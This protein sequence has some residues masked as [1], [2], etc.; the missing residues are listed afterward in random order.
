[1]RRNLP[2]TTMNVSLEDGR[3]IV[4]KTDLKGKITYVNPYFVEVSGFTEEELLG[5]PH[6]LVRH[7]DMPPE[8][9]A[10]LWETLKSGIPWTGMVKNRCKNGDYYWVYANVTPVREGDNV[11]GYMSVRTKPS[12]AQIDAAEELYRRI[13]EGKAM[14]LKI[15]RG[16]PV[17]TGIAGWIASLR[18]M[19]T[20]R[21]LAL[22]MGSVCALFLSLGIA[23]LCDMPA[24]WIAALCATGVAAGAMTWRSLHAGVVQPVRSALRAARTIAGGDLRTSFDTSRQDDIGQLMTALQQMNVNLQAI[25]G[26]VRS[27]VD[28]MSAGS[29]EIAAGNLGLSTRTE[30]QAASLEETASTMEELASAVQQNA[31]HT[32]QANDLGKA[33]TD[34]AAQGCAAIEQMSATMNGISASS[35]KIV[36]II[37]LIDGIAFQTNILALNA[38]VEAARAGEQG[39]GFAVVAAEVRTLAQRSAGA[40]KEIKS[41]IEASVERVDAGTKQVE[42]AGTTIGRIAE[43]VR[44][45]SCIMG[46]ISAASSEQSDGIEQV[47][48]ALVQMDETTQQNAALVEEAAAASASLAEQANRLSQV[49]AMFRLQGR[50]T[51]A[52][53]NVRLLK[54]PGGALRPGSAATGAAGATHPRSYRELRVAQM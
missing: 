43:S 11:V 38:A 52:G 33:T 10:D 6:N 40:A 39:R 16:I 20:G 48:L 2:V 35:H 8:A 5:S 4:S 12:Q 54:Q 25:I 51:W 36:E 23:A 7:P 50:D 27:N 26:D 34:L 17:R 41:L 30:E 32:S 44:Q 46:D 9:F 28:T 42:S 53:N 14:G 3:P 47:N 29:Q 21:R 18:N 45:V 24:S 49:I 31:M 19:T 15:R 22:G 37:S 1:M 13:R